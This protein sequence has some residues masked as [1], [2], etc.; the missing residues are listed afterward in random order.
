MTQ[1]DKTDTFD[2]RWVRIME[3]TRWLFLRYGYAH[4]STQAI[5]NGARVSKATLYAYWSTKPDLFNSLI[6]RESLH[7]F[8][9]WLQRVESDPMGGTI[10]HMLADGMAAVSAN[11]VLPVLYSRDSQT[12]GD[13]LRERGKKLTS[14]RYGMSLDFIRDLQDAHLIRADLPADHINHILTAISVGLVSVGELYD[15]ARFPDFDAIATSL[16]EMIQRH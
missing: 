7:A 14:Q 16:G 9:D 2:A 13:L 8:D 5:A 12:L 11:P 10:G 3:T 15:S 1:Q 6:L 4:T